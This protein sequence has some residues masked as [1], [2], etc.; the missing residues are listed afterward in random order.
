MALER[1]LLDPNS[2]TLDSH[3]LQIVSKY[4]ERYKELIELTKTSKRAFGTIEKYNFN[5]VRIV[6]KKD[7][8]RYD[9]LTGLEELHIHDDMLDDKWL[10]VIRDDEQRRICKVIF[11]PMASML[12]EHSCRYKTVGENEW[13]EEKLNSVDTYEIISAEHEYDDEFITVLEDAQDFVIQYHNLFWEGKHTEEFEKILGVDHRAWEYEEEFKKKYEKCTEDAMRIE[14]NLLLKGTYPPKLK[15]LIKKNTQNIPN[16]IP[17]EY[18]NVHAKGSIR[19]DTMQDVVI[20]NNVRRLN[21]TFVPGIIQNPMHAGFNNKLKSIVI[22][23]S[24]TWISQKC[25]ME[26]REL[27]EVKLSDNIVNLPKYLFFG[28]SKLPEIRLPKYAVTMGV[29]IFAYCDNL[30]NVYMNEILYM[31]R[32]EDSDVSSSVREKKHSQF[33][34][35]PEDLTIHVMDGDREI[36]SVNQ[37]M[38]YEPV[39]SEELFD[40]ILN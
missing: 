28:C 8:Q 5:P 7:V 39:F 23:N 10:D 36:D 21:V 32:D 26:C 9:K 38:Y 2:N 24:V 4:L 40:K 16:N 22:P 17:I 31:G 19:I 3:A 18:K 6:D 30:K 34:S 20:N 37:Y 12:L 25:F 11:W 15:K 29:F 35:T 1:R 33:D 13:H 14:L 27:E